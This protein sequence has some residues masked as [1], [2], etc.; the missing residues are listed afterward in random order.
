VQ[1]FPTTTDGVTFFMGIAVGPNGRI[2]ATEGPQQPNYWGDHPEATVYRDVKRVG[3]SVWEADGSNYQYIDGAGWLYTDTSDLWHLPANIVWAGNS[4]HLPPLPAPEPPADNDRALRLGVNAT[5][6]EVSPSANADHD[7]TGP[8]TV[9]CWMRPSNTGWDTGAEP[10]VTKGDTA[11]RL[12]RDPNS[13]GVRFGTTG[14]SP[15]ALGTSE[16]LSP[17]VWHHIAA[18]YDGVYK[19]IYV[20][21]ALAAAEA[22][23]GFLAVNDQPVRLGANSERPNRQF[24]GLLDEVRI[25]NTARSAA[26]IYDAMYRR[27]TGDEPGLVTYFNFDARHG[28]TELNL[29][30]SGRMKHGIV[31]NGEEVQL[32]PTRPVRAIPGYGGSP[33]VVGRHVF[34]NRSTWDKRN[35]AANANDDA[36]IAPDKE[37]LFIGDKAR[38]ANYTSYSRGLNGVMV[39]IFN[40][41]GSPK[42]KDFRFR[43]G[44][45]RNPS[46]WADAPAP[47]SIKVRPGAGVDGTD[48]ITLIWGDN[49]LDGV[50]NPGEAVAGKWLE[51]TVKASPRTGLAS[52]DVFYFGNAPGESG[53]RL[54]NAIVD[55]VDAQTAYD[56]ATRLPSAG[57]D[58]RIDYNRDRI[59]NSADV[60]VALNNQTARGTAL[61]L[62]TPNPDG[63]GVPPDA[64]A[65]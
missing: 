45:N 60:R 14:L 58:S 50:A 8:F 26:E 54:A 43:Q 15:V 64:P 11:W 47:I 34:Y 41:P 44:N 31:Y 27:L 65:P 28:G 46:T 20:N 9:E 24:D 16:P 25:W 10:L 32:N 13:G 33:F 36:A 5:H 57:L 55:G 3:L 23:T 61:K 6:V 63:A 19:Y 4:P 49:N 51:V 17:G 29:A 56:G 38:F 37:P 12:Q 39:D 52:D 2:V 22:V 7:F 48:R 42:A 35:P 18:V 30:A 21:G 1:T 53:D 40:L 59:V 62:V